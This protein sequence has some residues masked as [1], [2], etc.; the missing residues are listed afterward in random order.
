MTRRRLR[1]AGF[2]ALSAFMTSA[3]SAD[4][5][6]WN[7][8]ATGL[9]EV[10][11]EMA[12]ENANCHWG[13]MPGGERHGPQRRYCPGDYGYAPPVALPPSYYRRDRG[14]GGRGDHGRGRWD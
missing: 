13:P 4:P 10:A 7:A 9:T 1:L 5:A 12:W 8:M 11:D 6:L 3:C 14:H 2:I